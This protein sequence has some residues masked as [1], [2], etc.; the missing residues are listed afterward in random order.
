VVWGD[1]IA[2][3]E[4]LSN[5]L[6]N[7]I[8]YTP[9][10]GEI[11]MTSDSNP[12]HAVIKI[13]DTGLGIPPEDQPQIFQRRYRGVQAMGEIPGTGLGL[14]IAQD[15]VHQMQGRIEL[16]SPITDN[17]ATPGTEF[18]LWLPRCEKV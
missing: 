16:H 15:L 3:Q 6:D 12:T 14:A 7:G 1:A 5:L 18:I 9:P 17:P 2:L 10:G 13:S 11:R 8:K 4:V